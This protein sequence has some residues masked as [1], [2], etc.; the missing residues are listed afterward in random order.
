MSGVTAP[1][2]KRKAYTMAV[3][4][5]PNEW[6]HLRSW[7]DLRGITGRELIASILSVWCQRNPLPERE[8]DDEDGTEEAAG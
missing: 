8:L 3:E 2:P 6:D 7:S 5:F 1:R 4:L